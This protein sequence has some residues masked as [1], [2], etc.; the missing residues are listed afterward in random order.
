MANALV[1]ALVFV[2]G[3]VVSTIIIYIVTRLF[4]EKKGVARAFV[5]AVIGAAGYSIIY[6]LL[7]S[8]WVAAI[9]GGFVWLV[10]LR[11]LYRIGWLKALA[12]AVIIWIAAT[13]VG[14]LLPTVPGPL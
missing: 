13:I 9:V 4:G 3:L 1:S 10:A 11:V 7:D 2:A 8:G 6:H 5:T 14:L 12:V